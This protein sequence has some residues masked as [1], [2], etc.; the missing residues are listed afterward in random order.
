MDTREVF[1]IMLSSFIVSVSSKVSNAASGVHDEPVA[2]ETLS[3]HDRSLATK[4]FRWNFKLCYAHEVFREGVNF[5]GCGSLD[6][7]SS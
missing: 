2:F 4:G 5:L 7:V 3:P 1:Y 6:I